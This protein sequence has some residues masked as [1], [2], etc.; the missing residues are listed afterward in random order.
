MIVE[1][2]EAYVNQALGRINFVGPVKVRPERRPLTAEIPASNL[3]GV[4]FPPAEP[5]V[6]RVRGKFEISIG[7]LVLRADEADLNNQTAE[8]ELRGNV[9]ATMPTTPPR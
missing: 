1:G 7:T 9:S 3:A 8:M 2:T 4:P 6:M 5:V